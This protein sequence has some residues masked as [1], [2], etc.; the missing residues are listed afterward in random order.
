MGDNNNYNDFRTESKND[1]YHEDNSKNDNNNLNNLFSLYN[2]FLIKENRHH[3]S[4]LNKKPTNKNRKE[5]MP[6]Y[7]NIQIQIKNDKEL[8]KDIYQADPILKESI[9][10][11]PSINIFKKGFKKLFFGPNGVVTRKSVA[12]RKFYK[13]YRTKKVNFNEKLYIGSMDLFESLGNSTNYNKRLKSNQKRIIRINGNFDMTNP[14]QMKIR[15]TYR[16]FHKKIIKISKEKSKDKKL[17]QNINSENNNI[18]N[19][20]FSQLY[21]THN[22]FLDYKNNLIPD[23]VIKLSLDKRRKTTRQIID[24]NFLFQKKPINISATNNSNNN[25]TPSHKIA[26]IK[27]LKPIPNA[28]S[29]INSFQNSIGKQ[30]TSKTIISLKKE[31]S[32]NEN[33]KNTNDIENKDKNEIEAYISKSINFAKYFKQKKNL[34]KYVDSFKRS[35]NKRIFSSNNSNNKIRDKLNNFIV[36]NEKYVIKKNKYFLKKIVEPYDEFKDDPKQEENFKNFAKNVDF[37]NKAL[38]SQNR[39]KDKMNTINMAYTFK[40]GFEANIPV[41]EYIKKLKKKKEKEKENKILKSVRLHFNTNSKIIH[42][43]TISL[44]D[45]KKKFNY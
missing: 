7:S 21:K 10:E 27:N 26:N 35:F 33:I 38:S 1:S 12:L 20:R 36:K 25:N 44:D 43:L 40:V 15:R 34:K 17:N 19:R 5:I 32:K 13:S 41:K 16:N 2:N 18:K 4:S 8:I 31:I 3:S 14:R 9:K 11:S 39:I 23:S 28:K 24:L 37:S 42:N 6:K 29:S 45:I 22:L 30:K